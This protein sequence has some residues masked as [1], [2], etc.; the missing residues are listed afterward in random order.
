MALSLTMFQAMVQTSPVTFDEIVIQ[1]LCKHVNVL[2]V[3]LH[4]PGRLQDKLSY[5][6]TQDI[7]RI[8]FK[9][10]FSE[11]VRFSILIF[12]EKFKLSGGVSDD[13][14]V[15]ILLDTNPDQIFNKYIEDITLFVKDLFKCEILDTRI[16]L[17]NG[18]FKTERI[19][20]YLDFAERFAV[21][22][23]SLYKSIVMPYQLSRGRVAALKLYT[24]RSNKSSIHFDHSGSVQFFAYHKVTDMI[25]DYMEFK[26]LL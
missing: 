2:S 25:V 12:K 3:F 18:R 10:A 8:G 26:D 7:G 13:N 16:N 9:V 5:D 4:P 1:T 6:T 11:D 14:Q 15:N 22:H 20:N 17:I 19:S 24:G 21:R 23:K